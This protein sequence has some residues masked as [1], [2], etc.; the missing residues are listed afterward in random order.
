MSLV[1]KV[2]EYE[3]CSD[4]G[5]A[6]KYALDDLDAFSVFTYEE[7]TMGATYENPLPSSDAAEAFHLH[8]AVCED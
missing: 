1:G 2:N 3:P 7:A 5:D 6:G 8:Q 4:G